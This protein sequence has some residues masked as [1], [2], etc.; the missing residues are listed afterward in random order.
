MIQALDSQEIVRAVRGCKIVPRLFP[1]LIAV[2]C[3]HAP[4]LPPHLEPHIPAKTTSRMRIRHLDF[5]EKKTGTASCRTGL[6]LSVQFAPL[7]RAHCHLRRF[8]TAFLKQFGN[9]ECQFQRLVGI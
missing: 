5:S 3:N 9:Q 4:Q 7:L 2:A 8:L 6:D 1:A